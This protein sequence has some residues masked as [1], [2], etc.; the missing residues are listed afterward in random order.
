[1][2]DQRTTQVVELALA[3]AN[4]ST[5]QRTTQ[6]VELVLA[7]TSI[8]AGQRTTQVVALVLTAVPDRG[9]AQIG[10]RIQP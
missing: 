6:V 4:L 5:D 9:W 10:V 8:T 7:D 3:E 2:A 1:M